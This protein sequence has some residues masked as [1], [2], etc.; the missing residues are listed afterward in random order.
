MFLV[1]PLCEFGVSADLY[2]YNFAYSSHRASGGLVSTTYELQG[3][4]NDDFCCFAVRT[5]GRN[6]DGAGLSAGLMTG[7][8]EAVPVRAPHSC[9]SPIF[10]SDPPDAA[11]NWVDL[12]LRYNVSERIIGPPG[13]NAAAPGA[14]DETDVGADTMASEP[15][16]TAVS[17]RSSGNGG[18][19]PS[20]PG[21]R[22]RLGPPHIQKTM[23]GT[24]I[25]SKIS[26][27]SL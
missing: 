14:W 13:F 26:K 22:R 17:R 4:L 21:L 10:Q 25:R 19:G 27:I 5:S 15:P 6:P 1:N 23:W 11:K 20:R 12:N 24:R 18:S 8:A 2:L 9:T 7:V 16:V 3:G